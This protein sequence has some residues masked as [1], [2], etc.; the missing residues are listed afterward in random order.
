MTTWDDTAHD[1]LDS[2]TPGVRG[3][4]RSFGRDLSDIRNEATDIFQLPQ[5]Y[6][7]HLTN[8]DQIPAQPFNPQPASPQWTGVEGFLEEGWATGWDGQNRTGVMDPPPTNL[9]G[10]PST[11]F[12]MQGPI[13]GPEGEQDQSAIYAA[14]MSY[15][16]QAARGQQ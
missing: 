10:M 16:V 1:D 7:N 2:G 13:V 8:N 3:G 4:L 5:I 14:L 6:W 9:A 11:G 12:E 15:L